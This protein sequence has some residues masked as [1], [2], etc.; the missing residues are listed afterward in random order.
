MGSAADRECAAPAKFGAKREHGVEHHSNASDTLARECAAGLVRI[1]DAQGVGQLVAGQV[2][3]GDEHRNAER[4]R[5]RDAFDRCDA[6]VDG[7]D[8]VRLAL[9]SQPDDFRSEPVAVFETIR[10]EVVDVRPESAQ[11]T[12]A[13]GAAGGA[14]GVVVGNDEKTPAVAHGIGEYFRHRLCVHHGVERNEGAELVL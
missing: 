9:G 11:G 12:H 4:L 8:E 7:D 3:I 5:F 13:D 1:H 10:H 2:M 14:V 6:V